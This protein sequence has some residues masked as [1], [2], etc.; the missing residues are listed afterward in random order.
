MEQTKQYEYVDL[1]LPSGL[2]W[3]KCNVGAEKETD[4]GDYFMWGSTKPNAKTTCNWAKNPFNNNSSIYNEEY[5]N[6]HKSE[7]LDDKD[8]LKSEF[9]AA[10]Q[11]MGGNWRMPTRD[12]IQELL[13]NTDNERDTINGVNGWKFTSKTDT[14]KYIFIP[15]AGLCGGGSVGSVGSYGSVWSSS[16]DTSYHSNA[17][18]LYF[19]SGDCYVSNFY[20][21]G[22][23]SVRG[24]RK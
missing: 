6:A 11:I 9:D 8:N 7:W 18:N 14:S 22:G 23:Q 13:D 2:K 12:E 1:G 4:Y 24:V 10:T 3:A 17:W 21:C 15:A 19:D 5:F 16:L 20:R